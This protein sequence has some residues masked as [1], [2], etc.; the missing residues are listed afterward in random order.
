MSVGGLSFVLPVVLTAIGELDGAS[1]W[2]V[3]LC[4]LLAAIGQS[5]LRFLEGDTVFVGMDLEGL[6][7][8]ASIDA[9]PL[10]EF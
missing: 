3:V 5:H 10:G 8:T 9:N 4:V 2:S 1:C 7:A 6:L